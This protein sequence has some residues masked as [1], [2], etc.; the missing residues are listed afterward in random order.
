MSV[1]PHSGPN[2]FKAIRGG[3]HEY[4]S[5]PPKPK[6]ILVKDNFTKRDRGLRTVLNRKNRFTLSSMNSE[7]WRSG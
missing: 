4:K 2:P 6:L 7:V 1:I 5:E 3:P